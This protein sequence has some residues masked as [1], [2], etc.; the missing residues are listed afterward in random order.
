MEMAAKAAVHKKRMTEGMAKKKK[1]LMAQ[2]Q[3]RLEAEFARRKEA[4]QTGMM[5]QMGGIKAVRL[6]EI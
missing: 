2:Q 6:S 1:E 3:E 5:A 4:G